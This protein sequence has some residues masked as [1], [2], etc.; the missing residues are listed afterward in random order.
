MGHSHLPSS[1][2]SPESIRAGHELTDVKV[3]P[4]LQF[5]VML[6][7]IVALTMWGSLKMLHAMETYLGGSS[8]VRHPMQEGIAVPAGPRL[9]TNEARDLGLFTD[10]IEKQI[11]GDSAYGWVD[12][13]TDVVRVPIERAMELVLEQGLPHRP[14][15]K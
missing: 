13:P 8:D 9:Q 5:A 1:G 7:V 2:G 4:L 6:T 10:S 3:A 15:A 14:A 11:H 12:R